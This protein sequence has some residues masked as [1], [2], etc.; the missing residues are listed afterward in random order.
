M[1]ELERQVIG[2]A[3]SMSEAFR[4]FC[5]GKLT[6]DEVKARA[7]DLDYSINRLSEKED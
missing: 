4:D 2:A 3:I 7:W 6:L 1:R 5:L